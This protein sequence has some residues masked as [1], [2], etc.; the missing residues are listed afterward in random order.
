MEKNDLKNAIEAIL[1]A[2][3]DPISIDR[4]AAVLATDTNTI[5]EAAEQ[6]KTEYE[7]RLSGIC[8]V[9]LENKLQMCSSAQYT[10]YVRL[11]LESRKPPQL[12]QPA[13]EV[14][15]IVAYFQ[16]VTKAYIEQVRGVDSGYTISLLQDRG[17][18]E[19]C[20]RLSVPGRPVLYRTTDI[21]LR[22]FGITSLEELPPLPQAED[23]TE[24]QLKL[25]NAIA[26]LQSESIDEN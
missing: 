15:S 10:E 26:A 24:E 17:L 13:A 14:L 18:I 5:A 2:S 12:T 21:F 20:G 9:R 8:I 25:E 4:I 1:F 22:T 6:L 16:P 19:A 7:E 3:G 11:A 23:N